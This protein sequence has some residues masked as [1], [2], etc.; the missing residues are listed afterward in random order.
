MNV[1]NTGRPMPGCYPPSRWGGMRAD[2]ALML[3]LCLVFPILC[4]GAT[5]DPK[6]SVSLERVRDPSGNDTT[7]KDTVTLKA[8]VK[9]VSKESV[10]INVWHPL[11]DY[12][13]TVT[14]CKGNRVALSKRGEAFFS[15]DRIRSRT[16]SVIVTL[17]PGE[18]RV[19]TWAI[20][21]FFQF[22]RPGCYRVAVQREFMGAHE[23]DSSNTLEVVLQ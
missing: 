20:D 1:R 11:E 4:T 5:P 2:G 14:D 19:D 9:N 15:K 6:L 7:G 17:E 8:T 3:L 16:A 13:L 22:S 18:T 21:D 10:L 12:S 23:T